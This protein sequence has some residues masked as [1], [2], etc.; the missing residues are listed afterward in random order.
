MTRART[1]LQTKEKVG[2]SAQ[3]DWAAQDV[4]RQQVS[5][6]IQG[7]PS[8][9]EWPKLVKKVVFQEQGSQGEAPPCISSPPVQ[10]RPEGSTLI[11]STPCREDG[12][13]WE[14]LSDAP[15]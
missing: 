3:L 15:I 10:H 12:D 6:W 1:S 2:N 5:T 13:D 7:S 4:V 9:L 8:Q 14:S 11:S